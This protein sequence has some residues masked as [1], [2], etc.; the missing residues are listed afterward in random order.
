MQFVG[1]VLEF[2]RLKEL[3]GGDHA[4][5]DRAERQGGHGHHRCHRKSDFVA[6]SFAH[7]HDMV[8]NQEK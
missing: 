1:F 6:T 7:V 8:R 3:F 5:L 4:G 2:S